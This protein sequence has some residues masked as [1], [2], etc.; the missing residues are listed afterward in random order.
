MSVNPSKTRTW[1]KTTPADGDLLEA[2]LNR[3]YENTNDLQSQAD[4]IPKTFLQLPD[5]PSSFA[6]QAGKVPMVNPGA[7]GL[8]FVS[9][10]LY[11]Q[12]VL[13]SGSEFTRIVASGAT[14]VSVPAFTARIGSSIVDFVAIDI[15]A[16]ALDTG[17]FPTDVCADYHI[18][19][20]LVGG[21]PAL[22]ISLSKTSPVGMTSPVMIGGFHYGVIRNSVTLADVTKNRIVAQS[23]WTRKRGCMPSCYL[24]GLQNPANFDIGGM[25]EFSFGKWGDIYLVSDP[26]GLTTGGS[27]NNRPPLSK[28]AYSRYA[29]V[30]LTGSEGLNAFDFMDRAQ[31]VGKRLLT[32]TEWIQ[33]ASGSPQGNNSDN[34]NGWT[35][36][37][38]TQRT[39]TGALTVLSV[40]AG[41]SVT[42][43]GDANYRSGR[44]TSLVGARDCVGNVYEWADGGVSSWGV[45][46]AWRDVMKTG[47][48]ASLLDFGQEYSGGNST[49]PIMGGNWSHGVIAGSR[50]LLVSNDPWGVASIFGSRFA[51]DSL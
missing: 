1:G 12:P 26:V 43:P 34:L 47:E 3:I 23:V 9:H 25:V 6:G 37:S 27:A 44:N 40:P 14:Q 35:A 19:A 11:E 48:S 13:F 8:I 5:T 46:G 2:E 18:Y 4:A 31:F 28:R 16:S 7:S 45:S 42:S 41:Y 36:T 30:P 38:N 20:G 15:G 21:L 50:S 29:T 33:I 32:V 10:L 49:M 39:L 17:S 51:C 22:R 24:L